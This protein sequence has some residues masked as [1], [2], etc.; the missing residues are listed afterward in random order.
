MTQEYSLQLAQLFPV[1]LRAALRKLPSTAPSNKLNQIKFILIKNRPILSSLSTHRKV[2][3]TNCRHRQMCLCPPPEKLP[4]ASDKLP[5]GLPSGFSEACCD[6]R[7]FCPASNH[8]D[9]DGCRHLTSEGAKRFEV[10]R[11]F[12]RYNKRFTLMEES[13]CRMAH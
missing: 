8:D 6:E 13:R 1:S 4:A 2:P 10:S 11:G 5:F 9:E 7:S 12:G 3:Q